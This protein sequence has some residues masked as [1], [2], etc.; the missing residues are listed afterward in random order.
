MDVLDMPHIKS[1][2]KWL[3]NIVL[4]SARDENFDVTTAKF[5]KQV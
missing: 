2:G 4:C 3:L 1:F 5:H